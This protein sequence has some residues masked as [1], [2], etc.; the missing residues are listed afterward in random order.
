VA[1]GSRSGDQD[2]LVFFFMS[3]GRR[4]TPDEVEKARAVL[5]VCSGAVPASSDARLYPIRIMEITKKMF[6]VQADDKMSA[7]NPALK[8][9]R[10]RGQY[11]ALMTK[12]PP[13]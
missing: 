1:Q 10:L 9:S 12:V 7:R 4:S 2:K 8:D 6:Q 5:T 11:E 13:A 3:Y